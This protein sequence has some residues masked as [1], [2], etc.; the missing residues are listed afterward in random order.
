MNIQQLKEILMRRLARDEWDLFFD[1]RENKL[2]IIHC[3]LKKGAHLSLNP[4][5]AK[6]EKMKEK[7]IDEAARYIELT[8][9]AM[10]YEVTLKGNEKRIF[11]VIRS[12]SFP[13]ESRD[14]KKLVYFE[15]TA[16]TR[17][18]FALDSGEYYQLIDEELMAEASLTK[19]SLKE[20]ALFNLRSLPYE[21]KQDEVA[22]NVFYFINTNDG[23]DASRILDTSIMEKIRKQIKGEFAC[24]VPHQDVCIFADIVNDTGYD[25][26]GQM[27]FQFFA[28]GKI[29]ITA[30]SFFFKEGELEPM[31]ILAQRKPKQ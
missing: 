10:E 21:L 2:S 20:T 31:F 24:A 8:L 19:E 6:Y 29:P 17:I 27:V 28:Q 30:L 3:K 4:L 12:T 14:G 13:T 15:H 22:G 23:Y 5:L 26:L 11:P 18:F 16:E 9:K 25:V 1:E 7:A